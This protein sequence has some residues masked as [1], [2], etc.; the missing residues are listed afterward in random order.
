MEP[1]F[2]LYHILNTLYSCGRCICLRGAGSSSG[3][4]LSFSHNLDSQSALLLVERQFSPTK[5][6]VPLFALSVRLFALSVRGGG[7]GLDAEQSFPALTGGTGDTSTL[8]TRWS[9]WVVCPREENGNA[10][11]NQQVL[12]L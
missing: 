5:N 3:S 11:L 2:Y 10:I 8:G 1:T 9:S 7:H 6:N 12:N 4:R